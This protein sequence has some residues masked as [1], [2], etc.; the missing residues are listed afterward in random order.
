MKKFLV[1]ICLLALTTG[2]AFAFP[3]YSSTGTNPATGLPMPGT[4]FEDEN[5]DYLVNRVGS[6]DTIDVGDV[7]V[8]LIEFPSVRPF[9]VGTATPTNILVDELVALA[10]IR[11]KS[12]VGGLWFFEQ[13]GSTPMVQFFTGLGAV[14]L[15][16]ANDP[17][18]AAGTAALID[19]TPLWSFS[20]DP[21]DNDTFWVFDP[22]DPGAAS[23][24][25]VGGLIGKI[26]SVNYALNQVGGLDIFNQLGLT[27][28]DQT[29]FA[30]GYAAVLAD[31]G[32]T[33]GLVDLSGSG[34]IY[35]GLGLHNGAFAR[36]DIDTYLNPIPEP[37]TM[38]LLGLG[39]L[40]MAFVGRCRQR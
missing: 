12:T 40:G 11:L 20:I 39:L 9:P 30:A 35:G 28:P 1:L 21:L 37:A 14:N 4:W 3:M 8:S 23:I 34:D 16:L 7:L 36:S 6:A 10:T 19:G 38:T 15:D 32:V 22:T 33:D 25:T 17:N 29:G 31:G 13:D 24:S 27:T 2:T 5:L 26:G 18:L